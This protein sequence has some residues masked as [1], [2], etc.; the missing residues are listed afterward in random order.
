MASSSDAL[1]A[2][3][4]VLM[5]RTNMRDTY[6]TTISECQAGFCRD[7]QSSN[8]RRDARGENIKP[9][10][11]LVTGASLAVISAH[12]CGNLRFNEAP[13]H[14]AK[15]M[16]WSRALFLA[17]VDTAKFFV[18]VDD[19]GSWVLSPFSAMLTDVINSRRSSS[20]SF[21][22]ITRSEAASNVKKWTTGGIFRLPLA[23]NRVPGSL[24][25]NAPGSV[26]KSKD[27]QAL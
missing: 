9:K 22:A 6:R 4:T 21:S 27:C 17:G 26:L 11:A 14:P 20:D 24:N 7:C 5:M 18:F 13:V 10:N 15:R 2:N 3:L 1:R 8:T 25:R 19:P 23:S 16:M 12:R